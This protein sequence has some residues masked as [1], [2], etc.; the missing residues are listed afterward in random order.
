LS[1]DFYADEVTGREKRKR[2]G[3]SEGGG[4]EKGEGKAKTG[5]GGTF[6][7]ISVRKSCTGGPPPQKS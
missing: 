1:A 6:C 4:M 3:T 5:G 2:S 7:R